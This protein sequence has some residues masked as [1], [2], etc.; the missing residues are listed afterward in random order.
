MRCAWHPKYHGFPWVYEVASWRGQGVVFSDGMCRWCANRWRSELHAGRFNLLPTPAAEPGPPPMVP[1]WMPR[2]GVAL[3]LTAA[4]ILA[5]RP[6]DPALRSRSVANAA[7]RPAATA[8]SMTPAARVTPAAAVTPPLCG[9]DDHERVVT[10]VPT[11]QRARANRRVRPASA[12]SRA[13]VTPAVTACP[14]PAA[15]FARP[16]SF[17][18][19]RGCDAPATT[20]VA[21]TG[22]RLRLASGGIE[23]P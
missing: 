19:S 6:L 10:A 23:A 14:R 7:R 3:A 2:V 21:V 1:A 20:T 16:I 13:R 5:A 11:G 8:P 17:A 15:M 18:V 9:H 4:V 22:R 12:I